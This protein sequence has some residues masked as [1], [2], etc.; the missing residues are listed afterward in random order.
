MLSGGLIEKVGTVEAGG[1]ITGDL[2]IEGDL[3]V[4]GSST[5]TYDEL[6]QG[7]LVID[8]T[9]TEALLIRKSSD[10]GDV[11]TIDT[12]GETVR[13]NSHD[14]S[15]KGL[16]LGATLVTSTA[17]ELN[18]LDGATLSTAELNYVDGVTSAIQ[19]QMDLKSPLASP[20]FT[21]TITVGSASLSEA[22]LE[23]LDG[24]TLS[25]SDLN[26]LDGVTATTAELN[27]LDVTTLGTAEASKAVTAGALGAINFNSGNLTNVDID[28]GT[29][30][31]TNITVGSG[32]TLDVSGGTFTLASDQIS[33]DKINGGTISAF[34]STGIDDNASSNALTIDSSQ[35]LA[36]TSGTL[37]V[38]SE[39]NTGAGNR[40][41]HLNPHGTGEVSVTATLDATAIK[42]ASGTA[43]TAIKDEDNMLSDS[44]TSLATQQSIKA[45]VDAVTTSLNAQ[46]LDFQGDSGGALNIDLD[47]EVLD[48]AGDGAGI[49]TAGSLNQITISGD[50]DSLTNFVANEH[51]DHS[52]V[53]IS[54]GGILS[55]GGTIA[56]N[57][58]ITLASSDVVHDSTTGFVANEHI[59]HSSVTLTAG[60]GLSGGGDLTSS[61]SFAVDLNELTT[62]TT[63]ADADFIAMVDATDSGSGKITFENL[64]DAIFSSVS[65]DVL[66][67]EAG[68][69]SIQANSVALATDTTGNYVSTAVAG[70][71]I[72]VSGA[73]GDVTISVEVASTT[74]SGMV[75]LAT[76]AETNTGTDTGRVVTPAG[77]TA[78][79]G[80]TAIVTVG[81]IGTGTWEATDVAV[82]HGGTGASDASTARTN[83]GVDASG[84]INYTH[85][86]H[87][88][89]VTSVSDGATTIAN[90]AVTYAKMQN[91][92]A[93]NR[94]L[95]RD[96]ALAGDVEEITPANVRTMINVEDGST[97][98]QSGAE[99]KTA[100]EAESNAYTDTKD[101]K[102]SGIEASADVTDSTNVNSA[103]AVMESDVSGT[104]AG[105][106]I[107]DDS[108][109]TASNTKLATSESIKAYVDSVA[110][111]L[112]VKSS[113][114]V[115]TTAN[116]TLSGEQAIDGVTT[117]ASRILV[118]DQSTASQNGIY[119]TAAGAWARAT[120]FDDP[121]EVAS[122]FVFISGG[123]AGADTGWVCTNEPESVAVGTDS[124]TFSQFSDAG[125]ITAG[126]G[127]TKSGNSININASQ[128]TI[129]S[130]GA[131]GTPSSGVLTNAT[132]LPIS[133]GVSGLA[134][135]VATFLATPTSA[136]LI[137]AVTNETGTGSLVFA[138]SPTLVTPALGTP[139]SGVAT[140]ITGLP[141]VAGT[142]G[143]LSVARGGTG[144]TSLT[145]GGILLGSG[146]GAVTAT[147]VL[148]DGEILVGDGT[149]D[150][151]ALDI[152]S[153]TAITTVGALGA[154]GSITSG[155]GTINNGASTIT[156]TG[157]VSTGALT[158]G[159][160]I[161]FN[162]GTIDLSTQTVDVTLNAA[163]DA[164]NFDSNTLSIDASNNRVGIGTASP[165]VPL[166]VVG[167]LK[168]GAA[169]GGRYFNLINDSANSYLDVSHG[170][171]VRTNGASSLVSSMFISTAGNVGIGDTSPASV[172][173]VKSDTNNDVNNGILFEAADS[174]NKLF[175]MYENSTGECYAGFYQADA[176]KAL[177]R[178]NGSS[179][180]NG[181]NVGIGTLAP[182]QLLDVNS[183]GGNMIADGY[184]THSLAV[185]KENIED[186]SGYLDKV[187]ACPAQKWN[188]KPF[189][190]ADEIKEAVLEEFGEDVLIEEAV[191]AQDA[192]YETV[193]VQEAVEEVLWSEDDDL[194]EDV[195]IGDVK[196]EAQE[197][198][199]EEQLVSEAIESKDAVYERQYSVW[200]ELFPED[201]SHR[202]KAL[203]NMPDGDLKT[204]ID[205][206]CEAK[207]VE[208]RPEDKWQKKRLGLVADAELTAEHLPEV[209]SIND[210]G[211][212]TGI[213]TMTYIGILHNA[214]QEL[215]AKVEALEN[216]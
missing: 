210:D 30:D 138:T 171:V 52:A 60:D 145:D 100:Y 184:D 186:A 102:L 175:Q 179:Y 112:N 77:L 25:T 180:L 176:I 193:V 48:I 11:F 75:E 31:G 150:P 181:G 196:T 198:E 89:D 92:S 90:D 199:T 76:T 214:I 37:T 111:G 197:E 26:I 38:Y 143:T 14:G 121:Q 106:I 80:D 83:L 202:Q 173:S 125:H 62:E 29:I 158:V 23:I 147:A 201:N 137:S 17:S 211:E 65:G 40:D 19:T 10:G 157:T 154:G 3:T 61:R 187:L 207:R 148:A 192:V 152:G 78:W 72:D 182:G 162:S 43:M 53:S 63:I 94:I 81:T 16:K 117:S 69:A 1:T 6:V 21:G 4:E 216:A 135:G 18:I 24:A 115:A 212:P 32:K 118:K 209:V 35:N 144:A 103:G 194:P 88:G 141:I 20:T 59:D 99:I 174:T 188:R 47:T 58:T 133:T 191:E 33:G 5:Y 13:I 64:E 140:N 206:W 73:T 167:T 39:V 109:A 208:M 146:T 84:T 183:G 68:V 129:T 116:I 120:D 8:T 27:Y 105:S 91:V 104:P 195:E 169:S 22:E 113:C 189:V 28:S 178:T 204:W 164:L 46:D 54:A 122:S 142:T 155:F 87:S 130:V 86:N 165:S 128:S 159:G 97:A 2:V 160:N 168:V 136:N 51:I 93:T 36:L 156:T 67:T 85:P 82:L 41:I 170:L 177:I 45:Y 9:D 124:I 74:N 166:D 50:H 55:G 66:I 71:G 123:T 15:S 131:L 114:A 190:S 151:V 126:T 110:Q 161:D 101:T 34:A 96:S 203:Y 107:D 172:L 139:A 149:T 95:G 12:S 57:R 70:D 134:T 7:G 79:T 108:M 127:L 185:Y 153:S 215:S 205:D 56:A 132:G 44:A 98:D 49:T 42:I 200:D 163:V 213:D 119:V